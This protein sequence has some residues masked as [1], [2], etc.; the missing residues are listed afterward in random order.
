MEVYKYLTVSKKS[1]Q[2]SAEADEFG[3]ILVNFERIFN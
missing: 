3:N 1:K 2:K